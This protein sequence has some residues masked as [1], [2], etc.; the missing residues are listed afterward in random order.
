[1]EKKCITILKT[2]F[3]MKKGPMKMKKASTMKMK[4]V[5][6]MK[7]TK[8]QA[9]NLPANLVKAIKAKESSAMKMKKAAMKLKKDFKQAAK[10]ISDS[11]NI[12]HAHYK[13]DSKMG[14]KLGK[15]MY[16]YIKNKI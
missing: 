3:K 4:K 7:V 12:A 1:L 8:K 6:A 14:E 16:K 15:E 13:S 9:A 10:N 5:S 2:K 11:R